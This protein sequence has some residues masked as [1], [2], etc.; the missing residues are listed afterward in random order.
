[1]ILLTSQ[2]RTVMRQR[3]FTLI[4]LMIVLVIVGILATIAVPA[5]KNHVTRTRRADAQI[6]LTQTASLQERYM[7]ECNFYANTLTGTRA[8]GTV[9]ASSSILGA[10][11]QSPD[12]HYTLSMAAGN[13]SGSC[14]GGS[15]SYSCGYTITATPV[16]TGAQAGNG[17]LR[18]DAMG[19]KQ[20]DKLNNSFASGIASWTDR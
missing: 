11:G 1:M 2:H 4:E 20:W 18:I 16:G 8:C 13:I 7:T 12:G 14:T 19:T 6:A 3:G 10:N 5:Y 15:A 9:G 17:A